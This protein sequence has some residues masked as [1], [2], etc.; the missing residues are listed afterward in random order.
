MENH[1]KDA[2]KGDERKRWEKA[3]GESEE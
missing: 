2:G 3:M 1:L